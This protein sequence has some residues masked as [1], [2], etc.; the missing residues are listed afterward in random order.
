MWRK[1]ERQRAIR[2]HS[3]VSL[4]ER[5]MERPII[6]GSGVPEISVGGIDQM[7]TLPSDV[8]QRQ[9]RTWPSLR[10]IHIFVATRFL[11]TL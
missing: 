7:H 10:H 3:R 8:M 1:S 4:L 11:H 5:H 9:A 6:T 2:R